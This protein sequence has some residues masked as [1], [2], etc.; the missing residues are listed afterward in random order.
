MWFSKCLLAVTLR[1]LATGDSHISL[2]YLFTMS[3]Q[4]IGRVILEVCAVLSFPRLLWLGRK[5][6]RPLHLFGICL[7]VL[8]PSSGST[9]FC[10]HQ[11]I[12]E[13]TSK[14]I[15]PTSVSCY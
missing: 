1:Y 4:F 7:T 13:V 8:V 9:L 14:I 11:Y 2:Q 5:Y 10:K 15:Y 12:L 3:K 6:V